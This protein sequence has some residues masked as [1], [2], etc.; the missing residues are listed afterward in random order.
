MCSEAVVLSR[1]LGDG[2]VTGEHWRARG[3]GLCDVAEGIPHPCPHGCSQLKEPG[4][5]RKDKE[6]LERVQRRHRG[7]DAAPLL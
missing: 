4:G 1:D 3:F 5:D 2:K 7:M 6:L